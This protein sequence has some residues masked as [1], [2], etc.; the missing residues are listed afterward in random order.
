MLAGR[1]GSDGHLLAL[2]DPQVTLYQYNLDA[3]DPQ[4][5]RDGEQHVQIRAFRLLEGN[6]TELAVW[7]GLLQAVSRFCDARSTYVH[8]QD[9]GTKRGQTDEAAA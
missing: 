1:D 2:P 8:Y 4:G 7:N 9:R 3:E 6:M 5:D